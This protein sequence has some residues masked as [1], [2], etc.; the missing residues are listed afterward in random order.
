MGM[1]DYYHHTLR[2]YLSPRTTGA[3]WVRF[4]RY[5]RS[6]YRSDEPI[7]LIMDNLSA[8]ITPEA[9]REA[10]R[11]WIRLGPIPTNSSHMNPV[12]THLRSIRRIALSGSD[13]PDWR[14][15]GG[16]VQGPMRKP[17]QRHSERVRK[18]KRCSWVRH[19]GAAK[20][21]DFSRP[22]AYLR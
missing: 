14:E 22:T 19:S 7:F 10:G 11:L 21:A 4:L 12:E 2:G 20:C 5:V 17:N 3:D 16:A 18:A 9:R 6:W 1:Y 13:P 8:H 15:L